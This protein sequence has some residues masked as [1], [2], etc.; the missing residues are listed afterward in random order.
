MPSNKGGDVFISEC[1][2][3]LNV[4]KIIRNQRKE[5]EMKKDLKILKMLGALMLVFII[6]VVIS[7]K[8]SPEQRVTT[9]YWATSQVGT[10][11]YIL[12]TALAPIFWKYSQNT[13]K[14]IAEAKKGSGH[15]VQSIRERTS[16]L[17]Q[18]DLSLAYDAY[19]GTGL[20]EGKGPWNGLRVMFPYT[21]TYLQCPLLKKNPIK[22]IYDLKG[23][24]VRTTERGSVS[25]TNGR[26]MLEI[27]GFDIQKDLVLSW[28]TY[29]QGCDAVQDGVVDVFIVNPGMPSSAISALDSVTDIKFLEVPEEIIK[30]MNE[31]FYNGKEVYK[32]GSI[33]GEKQFYRGMPKDF[34]TWV[35]FYCTVTRADYDQN[36]I[37]QITKMFWEHKKECEASLAQLQL[38]Y[39]EM[40][41]Q[42]S[43]P[44]F[45]PFAEGSL[46]Y[47]KEVGWIK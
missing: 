23:K 11:G 39:K 18:A 31:K 9:V 45:L 2:K 32:Y 12:P 22:S 25:D 33:I 36:I 21:L 43:S 29:A 20:F 42:I 46:K 1:L 14:T 24:K 15:T 19:F 7:T 26:R 35:S 30:K 41:P 40:I 17:G 16:D 38:V 44:E 28:G 10:T 34:K 3:K 4:D 5:F 8:A 13:I 47:Y 27:A 6:I 37:Y